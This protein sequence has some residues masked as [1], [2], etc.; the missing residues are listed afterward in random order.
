MTFDMESATKVTW[1]L[2]LL[3]S[4]G[5]KPGWFLTYVWLEIL[6]TLGR[7]TITQTLQLSPTDV[8]I[9]Q[10]FRFPSFKTWPKRVAKITGSK[11]KIFSFIW[12]QDAC[13]TKAKGWMLF[14]RTLLHKVLFV[15]A[16]KSNKWYSLISLVFYDMADT[17][18][19]MQSVTLRRKKFKLF[20]N[21]VSSYLKLASLCTS[22]FECM[23]PVVVGIA[24]K[25]TSCT[26]IKF[27]NL[28]RVGII[29]SRPRLSF[30]LG[31]RT[32]SLR[33]FR[34][35][36]YFINYSFQVNFTRL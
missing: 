22:H 25:G 10:I 18:P 17:E 31:W 26:K 8:V 16:R 7:E 1:V 3:G 2:P 20:G 27:R 24:T 29:W 9:H 34:D 33:A 35:V 19:F 13:D 14:G 12:L 36:A 5:R 30:I 28:E 6:L 15:C 21:G 32:W 11:E 4:F 23:V